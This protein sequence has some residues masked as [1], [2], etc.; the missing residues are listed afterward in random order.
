M[1]NSVSSMD[2]APGNMP[3][4]EAVDDIFAAIQS[5]FEE[6]VAAYSLSGAD[7]Q[8][9]MMSLRTKLQDLEP[10][11]M[12][13]PRINDDITSCIGQTKLVRINNTG[14]EGRVGEIVAK[15]EYTNPCLSIKDRT[16]I[17]MLNDAEAKGKIKSGET[18]IIDITS[19][20]TGE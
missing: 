7:R 19:G 16:V 20:N 11:T 8:I 5:T 13:A 6:K 1:G 10:S 17:Q 2:G 14:K 9:L 4:A 12:G 18:T 15:L 3:R